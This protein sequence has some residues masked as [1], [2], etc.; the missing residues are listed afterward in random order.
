[1]YQ[2]PCKRYSVSQPR[3]ACGHGKRDRVTRTI[4][5]ETGQQGD[6]GAR[7]REG[8]SSPLRKASMWGSPRSIRE[9]RPGAARRS[10]S[11]A[12]STTSGGPTGPGRASRLWPVHTASAAARSA[13]RPRTCRPADRSDRWPA[14]PTPSWQS[15]RWCERRPRQD[16]PSPA[17]PQRPLARPNG[18]PCGKDIR[19]A[20][21]RATTLHVTAAPHVHH[22]LLA[23]AAPLA[24]D[25]AASAARN[26][27]YADRLIAAAILTG[28]ALGRV[29]R[30]VA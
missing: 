18:T 8:V 19:C 13:P 28:P 22:A 5:A 2:N 17:R 23:A 6:V 12:W 27:I 9:P 10:P 7:R 26:R 3:N 14:R 29:V 30:S 11:S 15:R 24:A 21:G 4:V 1:M 25:G 20:E 16:R